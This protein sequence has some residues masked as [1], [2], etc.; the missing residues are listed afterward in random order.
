[1]V[2]TTGGA[3]CLV[4]AQVGDFEL[5]E[6]PRRVLDEVTED[7]FLV[8]ADQDDFLDVVDLADGLEAVPDDGVAGHIEEGLS[9]SKVSRLVRLHS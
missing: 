3:E 1:M 5:G 6:F 7:V 8:V 2:K 9:Q 4:F